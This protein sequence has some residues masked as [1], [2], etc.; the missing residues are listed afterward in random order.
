MTRF[1][2]GPRIFFVEC[3]ASPADEASVI[4]GRNRLRSACADIRDAGTAIEYLGA[5]LV[6][7]DELVLHMFV[8]AGPDV[9]RLVSERAT[10]RVERIVEAVAIGNGT[11]PIT[12]SSCPASL[13]PGSRGSLRARS[14][15]RRR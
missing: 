5:L 4:R 15:E 8:S 12:R 11:P 9:V 1:G 10:I 13:G 2:D 6:P 14:A 3:L 7:E